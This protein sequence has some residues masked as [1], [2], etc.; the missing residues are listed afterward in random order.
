[1]AKKTGFHLIPLSSVA[2]LARAVDGEQSPYCLNSTPTAPMTSEEMESRRTSMMGIIDMMSTDFANRVRTGE[3]KI[4]KPQEFAQIVN[5]ML[6]IEK[7][8]R[9]SGEIVDDSIPI[10]AP[11]LDADDPDV[12]A[13]FMT[14]FERMNERNNVDDGT[15]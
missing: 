6:A 9:E 12:Q 2:H 4:E 8:K 14:A 1:M 10:D 5:A 7:A 11:V 13:V 3:I 15:G